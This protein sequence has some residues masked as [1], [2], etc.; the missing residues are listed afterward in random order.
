MFTHRRTAFIGQHT[1]NG[2]HCWLELPVQCQC[3]SNW[4][5]VPSLS[6]SIPRWNL[7]SDIFGDPAFDGVHC[8]ACQCLSHYQPITMTKLVSISISLWMGFLANVVTQL[9]DGN[10]LTTCIHILISFNKSVM[11]ID[12]CADFWQ[13]WFV[14]LLK[15]NTWD[16]YLTPEILT[17]Q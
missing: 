16:P 15:M 4:L 11:V 2:K 6:G 13:Y 9:L 5:V 14:V 3:G 12:S 17:W 8:V 1:S 7:A 10:T